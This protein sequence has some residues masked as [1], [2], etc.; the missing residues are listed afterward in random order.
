MEKVST[1]YHYKAQRYDID[2]DLSRQRCLLTKP[3]GTPSD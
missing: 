3:G 1:P 2:K